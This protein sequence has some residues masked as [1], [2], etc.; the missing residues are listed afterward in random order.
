MTKELKEKFRESFLLAKVLEGCWRETPPPLKITEEELN[1]ISLSLQAVSGASLAWWKIK[2]TPLSETRVASE[3]EK[4]HR[5]YSIQNRVREHEIQ[6]GFN[7]L[8]SHNIEPILVKG[9]AINRLY[10]NHALRFFSDN[11]FL[12]HP[13]DFE[14]AKRILEMEENGR[15]NQDMHRGT[16]NPL[17]KLDHKSFEELFEKSQLVRLGETNVRVLSNEDHLRLLV[18]HWLMDGGERAS[19]LCDVALLVENHAQNFD[20]NLCLSN[21]KQRAGWVSCTIELAHKL[22]GAR[23]DNVPNEV[24]CKEMPAWLLPA[25][26]RAWKYKPVLQQ[27]W[28][29]IRAP[30][31]FIKNLSQRFPLNPISSTARINGSFN[32]TPRLP[33]SVVSYAIRCYQYLFVPMFRRKK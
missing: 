2:D 30:A 22:L 32:N 20:W 12:Y 14:K 9:W 33:Y 25:L 26:L 7:L 19:G 28:N 1:E 4:T 15:F 3:F 24:R 18:S 6:K 21:N 8:R 16:S 11:D 5:Y 13:A 10:P 27:P 17:R 23:V 31:K 29:D